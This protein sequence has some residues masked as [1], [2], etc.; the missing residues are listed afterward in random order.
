[1]TSEQSAFIT[2]HLTDDVR[3]LALQRDRY[4]DVDLPFVVAQIAGRQR[5][6]DKLPEIYAN[7]HWELPVTLSLEQCSS[8]QTAR[9][10][11]SLIEGDSL[12]DLTG[13]FGIDFHYCSQRFRT[14]D[15]VEQ[16]EELC[17][18]ARQNLSGQIHHTQ[19]E[20]YLSTC[21]HYSTIV[22]DPARRDQAG[23][24]VA[25]LSD[26]TPD[27]TRIHEILV[28]KADVVLVKLSPMLDMHQALQQLPYT[29]EV[30]IVSVNNE[31]KEML[32][33]MSKE[34]H[35]DITIHCVNLDTQEP[36]FCYTL[37]PTRSD[38]HA[39]TDT[40]FLYEPNASIM[41]AG[42]FHQLEEALGI[43]QLSENSHVYITDHAIDNFPGRG[44][45]IMDTRSLSKADCKALS[46]LGKANITTRNFP[47]KSEELR[48]KLK[49]KD[50]GD[51]YL[52]A[53]T[54]SEG[55]HLI[56]CCQK[57]QRL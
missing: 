27:L 40:Q 45:Q 3:Q 25:G 26:C 46:A 30:H 39:V 55:K 49:L 18:L 31:C 42:C 48:K 24:K 32:L 1:M 35:E 37:S 19:A 17:R 2:A 5:I 57:I 13:G 29:Y 38:V 33:L 43:P 41:K 52:I 4:P 47:M 44:F 28:E 22:I 15:Y 11:A 54:D 16:N 10:K 7:P 53:T 9:Y 34:P 51:N 14:A 50:G 23:R 56:F 21:P 8:Q 12:L 36:A 6:K 20:D